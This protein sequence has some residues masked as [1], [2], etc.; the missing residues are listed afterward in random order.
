MSNLEVGNVLELERIPVRDFAL[1]FLIHGI[2]IRLVNSHAA[3]GK[4]RSVVDGDIVQLWM[5]APIL[6]CEK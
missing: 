1:N 6:V 5:S 4:G 3:L 2:N